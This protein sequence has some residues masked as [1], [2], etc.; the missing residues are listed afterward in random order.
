MIII[1]IV[2]EKVCADCHVLERWV[3]ESSY[4]LLYLSCVCS[5]LD[6]PN[7]TWFGATR[8]LYSARQGTRKMWF[9]KNIQNAH[10]FGR[11]EHMACRKAKLLR[12]LPI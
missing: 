11:I 1:I 10:S 12:S 2:A 4:N 8:F 5:V 9:T 6:S 3:S 7:S